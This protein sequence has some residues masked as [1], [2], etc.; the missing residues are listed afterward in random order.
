M[1][2]NT[3]LIADDNAFVRTALYE[4]FEREPDLHVCAVVEN[5]R[6]AIEE[7]CRLH[8]DLI[9]LDIAMPVMNGLEAARVLRQMMPSVPLIM[10]SA[11]PNEV[12]AQ[13]A[14][15]IGIAGLISKS[16]KV[17]V[18]IDTIRGVLHRRAA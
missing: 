12:S 11:N 15:S 18:L 6:E 2:R 8:P 17:T 5:G 7:A 10:Y 1:M 9:V 13:S 4:V 16:E 3:V 14:R